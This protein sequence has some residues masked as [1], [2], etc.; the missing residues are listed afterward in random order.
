MP[1]CSRW[2]SSINRSC[3]SLH[4]Y[5]WNTKEM[6]F[7][8][9]PGWPSTCGL[10]GNKYLNNLSWLAHLSSYFCCLDR[11]LYP[12]FLLS[13]GF[14]MKKQ[15]ADGNEVSVGWEIQDYICHKVFLTYLGDTGAKLN[16]V[17]NLLSFECFTAGETVQKKG[18]VNRWLHE[19]LLFYNTVHYKN[20]Y[21]WWSKLRCQ[22]Y[23]VKV[24]EEITILHYV[25][26]Y[27][28]V[29]TLSF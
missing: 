2:Y 8:I 18:K 26:H 22:K 29:A 16:T 19:V 3:N 20:K 25:Y 17:L 6:V 4:T 7:S 14:R 11:S 28:S 23:A 9:L 15:L 24:I 27:I 12:L 13:V 1:S 10:L 5:R 21:L